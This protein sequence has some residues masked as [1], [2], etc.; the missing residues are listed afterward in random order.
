MA[1]EAQGDPCWL[2]DIMMM[3]KGDLRFTKNYSGIILLKIYNA[4]ER[5]ER[6]IEKNLRKKIKFVF[7]DIEPQHPRF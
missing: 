5:I 1:K 3:I 7:G 4:L 6:E 2:R